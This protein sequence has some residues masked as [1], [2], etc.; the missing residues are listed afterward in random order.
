[1]GV[2]SISTVKKIFII[3]HVFVLALLFLQYLSLSQKN[4]RKEYKFSTTCQQIIE[5]DQSV[6]GRAKEIMK[7]TKKFF[8]SPQKYLNL[9]SNCK[10]FKDDRG[11]ILKALSENED[12]FPIAYSINIYKDIEQFERL[13][14]AIYRPQNYYCIHVDKKSPDVFH[15]AV[16]KIVNCF[17]NVFVASNNVE[18]KWGEFSSL[19][20]TLICM[21]E[22]YGRS[23]LWKYLIN[24][25]G[26]EFPLR[27]NNELVEILKKLGGKSMVYGTQPPK[28]RFSFIY[29]RLLYPT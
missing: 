19:Q 25:T 24:L 22:L 13:L 5:G 4:S 7:R 15:R 26:Q 2:S 23:K 11:Y 17:T 29:T 1:M 28:N 16:E 18:V 12:Q 10:R 3:L 8:I 21:K 27:T 14:R 20:S 6:I 9:T